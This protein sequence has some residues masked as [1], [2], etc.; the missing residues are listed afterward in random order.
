MKLILK[1]EDPLDTIYTNEDGKPLYK[2][3]ASG[4]INPK[5]LI[6]KADEKMSRSHY[7]LPETH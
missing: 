7:M 3:E 4:F 6:G 2:I 1:K 5:T